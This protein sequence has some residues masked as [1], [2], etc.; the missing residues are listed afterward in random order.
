MG[1]FLQIDTQNFGIFSKGKQ[2]FQRKSFSTK[3]VNF[4]YRI[5]LQLLIIFMLKITHFYKVKLR[6]LLELGLYW[7]AGFILGFIVIYSLN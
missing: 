2:F 3:Y 4:A 6:V 1:Y 7:R 5:S